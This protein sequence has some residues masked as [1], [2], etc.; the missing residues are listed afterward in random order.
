MGLW[1]AHRRDIACPAF[2][3]ASCLFRDSRYSRGGAGLIGLRHEI[4]GSCVV[5]RG[6]RV[7]VMHD[8]VMYDGSIFRE[9]SRSLQSSSHGSLVYASMK[10]ESIW[11]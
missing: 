6:I 9:E 1:R 5:V 8:S 10:V 11:A 7:L 3:P 2:L 4:C